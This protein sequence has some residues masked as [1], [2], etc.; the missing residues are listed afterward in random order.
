MTTWLTDLIYGANEQIY[1]REELGR[2][3]GYYETLQARFKAAAEVEEQEAGLPERC[4]ALLR[5]QHPD[6][7]LYTARL[8]S[9][10][11]ASLR[12]V[13]QAMLLDEPRV[14]EERLLR[15]WREVL[16]SLDLPAAEVA[17]AYRV[18]AEEVLRGLTVPS[19]ALMEPFLK[20]VQDA[21]A[22]GE[23]AGGRGA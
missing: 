22:A 13:A 8:L 1:R 9:E 15:H 3:M 2:F 16:K 19:A 7:P 21:L 20:R 17:D 18:L 10:L 4:L 23:P 5:R 12:V 6:R 11:A 14:L